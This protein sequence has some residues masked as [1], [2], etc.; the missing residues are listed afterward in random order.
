M[1]ARTNRRRAKTIRSGFTLFEVLGV[2]L[3]TALLL[4][5]AISFFLNLTRQ[6]V[7]ATETTREVRRAAALIDRI[8][9]D[10]EHT[11]LVKKPADA[12]PLS[13]PWLFVAESRYSQ[14]GAERGSDQIKFIRRDLPRSS[15]GP[16]SDI[17]MVAYTLQ[18][19]EDGPNFELRR[20]STSELPDSLDREFPRSDDPA[21]FLIAD[22]LSYFA[23][24]FLD[25]SRQWK[26]RW[27]ST[28]LVD[29]SELP[30]AVEIEVALAAPEGSAPDADSELDAEPIHY[31]R[32]VELP[33]RPID[34]ETLLNPKEEEN[35]AQNQGEEG[36]ANGKTV[37]EC[38]NLS[39]IPR[40]GV[41]G[42]TDS[43]IATLAA[44][45]ENTPA[46]AFAQYA[47][48]LAGLAASG[49]V[50]PDCL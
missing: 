8:A 2:L 19:S 22:D 20:W 49:A 15:D 13:R 25:E 4:G 12:D 30:I 6:A 32:A 29:S 16:A 46:A 33:L 5:A 7:H 36:G 3:V 43:D 24:R 23:L 26:D 45:V 37:G 10:L 27:D 44:A 50:D 1:T 18:R 31:A 39:K 41:A 14:T 34:L 47:A 11:L 28:Q 42:L 40:S 38:V 17:A 21:S 48:A 9:A 35:V